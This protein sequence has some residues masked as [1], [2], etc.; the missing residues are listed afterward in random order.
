MKPDVQAAIASLS[1]RFRSRALPPKKEPERKK[2]PQP[3]AANV[4]ASGTASASGTIEA[5]G[6]EAYLLIRAEAAADTDKMTLSI[7]DGD[8]FELIDMGATANDADGNALIVT[9]WARLPATYTVTVTANT[10][11]WSITLIRTR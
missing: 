7:D 10:P 9:H 3:G 8:S 5:Q 1:L 11:A 4:I 2:T 6:S